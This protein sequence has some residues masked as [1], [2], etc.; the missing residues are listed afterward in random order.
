M[1]PTPSSH[2]PH[3]LESLFK[4]LPDLVP[5]GYIHYR[6]LLCGGALNH[7]CDCFNE[8]FTLYRK[9]NNGYIMSYFGPGVR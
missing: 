8:K 2:G 6:R 9:I 4:A 5:L 1:T 3:A 7:L